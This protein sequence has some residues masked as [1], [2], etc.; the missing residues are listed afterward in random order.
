MNLTTSNEIQRPYTADIGMMPVWTH[1]RSLFVPPDHQV[2]WSHEDL[3]GA[4]Y[5]FR[6]PSQWAKRFA[7]SW[8]RSG[9]SLGFNSDEV[10]YP[11]SITLPM[12]WLNAM[13]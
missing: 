12:G 4:F 5:L 10:F 2:R 8:P 13:S 1:W 7:F 9:R 11:A 3:K 6:L